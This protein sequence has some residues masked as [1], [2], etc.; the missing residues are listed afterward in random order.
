MTRAR[1]IVV[2]VALLWPG[3]ISLM[4]FV[5]LADDTS[6][7]QQGLFVGGK[8][9]QFLLPVAWVLAA[10]RFRPQWSKLFSTAGLGLGLAF[11]LAVAGAG[12]AVYY[13]WIKPAG[14]LDFAGPEIAK[15]IE[16]FHVDTV[17][18]YFTLAA[19]YS[20]IH[21]LLEEYYWR[22]FVFGQL[23]KLCRLW[24]AI[25]ISALGFTLHHV[26]VLGTYFGWAN[27]ATWL[28]SGA[29]TV[30]GVV[31][32]WLYA[33]SGSLLGPWLGHALV[34]AGIFLVGYDMV[35]RG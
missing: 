12:L 16:D 19:F 24:P 9:L 2:L 23:D 15:K 4:D 13:W 31:W 22:W 28:F 20:L 32:A 21:S 14:W 35:F 3:A 1:W 10:E 34:D 6:G 29:V 8:V 27:P 5:L 17:W 11:G 33:R 30:G 7:L 18:A 26:F 25:V